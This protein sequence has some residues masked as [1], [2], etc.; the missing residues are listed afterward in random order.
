MKRLLALV[1]VLLTIGGAACAAEFEPIPYAMEPAPYA[2]HMECF[3][4]DDA[5]YHDDSLDIRVETFRKDDTNVMVA[6][7]TIA[8]PSQLRTGTSNPKSPL[9]P[10]TQATTQT[11]PKESF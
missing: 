3:L 4:P 2:P 11:P 5:G 1:L 8:D 10:Q 6:Y 9:T 7:V